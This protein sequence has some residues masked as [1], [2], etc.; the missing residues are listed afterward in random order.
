MEDVFPI[1]TNNRIQ[2]CNEPL[3]HRERERE[4]ERE[5]KN[6]PRKM[7]GYVSPSF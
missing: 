1:V 5:K 2:L 6:L 4:R 7:A 3:R